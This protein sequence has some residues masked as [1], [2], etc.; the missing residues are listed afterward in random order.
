MRQWC[1]LCGLF[2]LSW[3]L[4]FPALASSAVLR[5]AD[6]LASPDLAVSRSDVV[7]DRTSGHAL[8]GVDPV[9]FYSHG[10]PVLGKASLEL[11]WAGHVWRF[12]SAANR[13]AFQR[14]PAFY[15]P[16]FGGYDPTSLA[17]GRLVE[18]KPQFFLTT[19]AGTLLF[20]DEDDKA[21]FLSTQSLVVTADATWQKVQA[22]LHP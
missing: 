6:G 2:L 7:H 16:R 20:R 18:G 9:S 3:T 19:K 5:P 12:V 17:E 10:K 15:M 8:W 21:M 1:Q 14:D 22:S 11:R 13:E 4:C